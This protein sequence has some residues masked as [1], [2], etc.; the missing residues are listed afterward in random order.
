MCACVDQMPVVSNVDCTGAD[1][2]ATW[3]ISVMSP[4]GNN[5]YIPSDNS[6]GKMFNDEDGGYS[7]SLNSPLSGLKCAGVHCH[8]K[9]LSSGNDDIFLSGGTWTN[10]FSSNRQWSMPCGDGRL[11]K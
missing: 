5:I 7:E 3:E 4:A 10:W 2:S 1:I 8:D 9:W 6:W 11:I